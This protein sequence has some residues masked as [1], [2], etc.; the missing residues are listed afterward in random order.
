MNEMRESQRKF[1]DETITRDLNE[2][3]AHSQRKKD[4]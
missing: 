4:V 3:L 2:K 1:N